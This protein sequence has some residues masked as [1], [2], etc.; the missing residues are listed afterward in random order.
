[1]AFARILVSAV[2]KGCARSLR[3]L[4][5]LKMD[6]ILSATEST[7]PMDMFKVRQGYLDDTSPNKV[8]LGVGA[9]RTDEGKP[10]VLPVVRRIEIEIANDESTNHEYSMF[11][12]EDS[13]RKAATQFLLGE[14]IMQDLGDRVFGVQSLGGTGSLRI[15]AEFLTKILKLHTIYISNPTWENHRGVFSRGGFSDIRE[16]RYWDPVTR[17]ININGLLEDL[18]QAPERSVVI[19]HACAHN[20]TGCD[21]TPEQ[22]T[23][24]ANVM[25]ERKL[26]TFF[27]IAYQGFATGDLEKDAWP[28]RYF[29]ER[30]FELFCAQSFSKNAGLYNERIG[31]L[32]VVLNDTSAMTYIQ[33]H[34]MSLVRAMYCYPSN[35]GMQIVDRILKNPQNFKEWKGNVSTMATRILAMRKA[36]REHLEALKTPGTWDHITNQ[37][38]MFSYTGLTSQQIEFLTKERHIYLLKSS[39][40]NM[41]G[42]NT[43]NVGYVA[44]AIH[45][46][47]VQVPQ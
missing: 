19:L 24:I 7:P 27:D 12:G 14:K 11:L 29:T 28:V 35:H 10:W 40:I 46:A 22:W 5:S 38:G 20:P 6:S 36:L 15:A 34:I 3:G 13:F 39:R 43:K 17:G 33:R 21:P 25:Q 26:F 18:N 47:V 8:D 2:E 44:Q 1:M 42:L 30:G 9:Y 31:N 45:D 41:C 32:T 37:R 23:K 4:S 16:Y